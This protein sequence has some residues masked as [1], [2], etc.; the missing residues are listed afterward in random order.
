M[1][2][3]DKTDKFSKWHKIHWIKELYALQQHFR[4]EP[5]GWPGAMP[6]QPTIRMLRPP[7]CGGRYRPYNRDIVELGQAEK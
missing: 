3:D 6:A 1:Q 4:R 2:Q 5:A 7:H